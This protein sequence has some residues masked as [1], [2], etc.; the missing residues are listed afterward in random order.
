MRSW[1][2][3]YFVLVLGWSGVATGQTTPSPIVFDSNFDSLTSSETA[4]WE[5]VSWAPS[6]L[7]VLYPDESGG[8]PCGQSSS[9]SHDDI[10]PDPGPEH[11]FFAQDRVFNPRSNSQGACLAGPVEQFRLGGTHLV[12][13][14]AYDPSQS[15]AIESVS[16]RF[17]F[18]YVGA[19]LASGADQLSAHLIARQGGSLY[20]SNASATGNVGG[21]WVAFSPDGGSSLHTLAASDFSRVVTAD[22]STAVAEGPDFTSSG[23]PIQFGFVANLH[24]DG[25]FKFL[26][27]IQFRTFVFDE[28]E[29][30]ANA[31][32]DDGDGV[33]NGLDNCLD[34]PNA[35]QRDPE[36]DG[37]GAICDADFVGPGSVPPGDGVV[38]GPDFLALSGAFGCETG[39]ACYDPDIDMDGD[40]TIGGPE[41][42]KM[43]GAFGFPPGPSGLACAGTV[44]CP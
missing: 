4:I 26:E 10:N 7:C 17:F 28:V 34:V 3:A 21:G 6:P 16:A 8:E 11:S 31:F 20:I 25:S 2:L 41:F 9:E 1:S 27:C 22:L 36:M 37:Y 24:W 29:V 30:I 13:G 23:G 33:A 14:Y 40:G 15:G 44:P 5:L 38:G 43:S 35:D 32:D 39:D 42:L 12:P 18:R 19:S